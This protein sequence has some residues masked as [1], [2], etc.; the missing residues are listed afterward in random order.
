MSFL[1]ATTSLPA[2]YRPNDDAWATTAGT[3]NSR[4]KIEKS[5]IFEMG[6][7]GL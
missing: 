7:C 5:H 6:H 1:V 4:A 3:P 2:F